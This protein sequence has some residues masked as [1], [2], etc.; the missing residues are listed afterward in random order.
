MAIR[1]LDAVLLPV[2]D[3]LE[4]LLAVMLSETRV[5]RDR[6]SGHYSAGPF[7]VHWVIVRPAST[8]T[9][10]E[11][12]ATSRTT[13]RVPDWRGPC[14]VWTIEIGRDLML[15]WVRLSTFA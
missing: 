1:G 10:P 9:A 5:A 3:P 6:D 15:A 8:E 13:N 4:I 12:A 7:R 14:R 2:S 11:S